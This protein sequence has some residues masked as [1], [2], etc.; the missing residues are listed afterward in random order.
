MKELRVETNL[1]DI[2]ILRRCPKVMDVG[3]FLN[4]DKIDV[5]ANWTYLNSAIIFCATFLS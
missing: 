4:H 3:G 2:E 5:F 1:V